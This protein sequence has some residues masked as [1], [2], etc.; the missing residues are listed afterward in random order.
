MTRER[1][2]RLFYLLADSCSILTGTLLLNTIRFYWEAPNGVWE[3]LNNYL[4]NTKSYFVYFSLWLFWLFIFTLSG[5]YNK[6]I[7]KSRIDDLWSSLGSVLVGTGIEFLLLIVNDKVHD[8]EVY[9]QLYLALMTSTFFLVYGFRFLITQIAIYQREKKE[10]WPNVL[11]IGTQKQVDE[12]A[13][14]SQEM[15]FTPQECLYIEDYYQGDKHHLAMEQISQRVATIF[16]TNPPTE[17]YLAAT[18]EESSHL[19]HLLY[20][21]YSY[22]TPIRISAE[23]MMPLPSIRTTFLHGIPLVD[24]TE[25]KMSEGAKNVK[26]CF[27]RVVALLLLLLLSPLFLFLAIGVR[28]SSPGDIFFAQERIG[29]RG[30]P[31]MIYKF[32]TMYRDSEQAGPQLS[33]DGDPRITPIGQ[34]LRK[35][36]LDELPQLFNV[37]KGDM[38]FVGPRPE[39]QYYIDLLV[40]RA[41]YYYLLHNVLPGITSWGMVRYGYASNLDEMTERLKYDWLYYGNMSLKMDF[42]VLLHTV[43]VLIKGSGK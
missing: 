33:H 24:V 38:S 29:K 16:Q 17:I 2:F 32:R 39:R 15:R 36:R 43:T 26:W 21:L 4:F 8:T 14:A 37:L 31:F 27:D 6:P 42:T 41:P 34:T 5:Y 19:G 20:K 1:K 23:G 7:N 30:K 10:F 9:L 22:K 18:Q 25:T 3:V 35:Y 13:N 40:D 28:R 11:L 12:L